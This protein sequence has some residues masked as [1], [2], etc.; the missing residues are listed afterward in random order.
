MCIVYGY[1]MLK[2][3]LKWILCN[4]YRIYK[5]CVLYKIKSVNFLFN[6]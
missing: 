5:Y 1:I 3:V 6:Y 2:I 4:S